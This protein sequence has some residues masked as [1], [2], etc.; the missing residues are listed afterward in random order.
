MKSGFIAIIGLPNVGKSSILNRLI[1]QKVA[2]VSNKPQTTRNRILAVM[3]E[4]DAQAVF[5]DTPGIHIPKTKL[6]SYMVK[7]A[8]SAMGDVDTVL[9]VTEARAKITELEAEML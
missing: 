7:S 2:I 3:T 9:F 4:N 5:I 8:N 1:G 6:G